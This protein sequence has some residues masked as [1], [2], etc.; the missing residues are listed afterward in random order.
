MHMGEGEV[1]I[2]R[3]EVCRGGMCVGRSVCMEGGGCVGRE[4]SVCR[5]GGSV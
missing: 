3:D 2:G 5:E 4:E 1:C